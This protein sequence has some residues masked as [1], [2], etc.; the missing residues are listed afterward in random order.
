MVYL[1]L[2]IKTII[3]EATMKTKAILIFT[4]LFTLFVSTVSA[5]S[6]PASMGLGW[7]SQKENTVGNIDFAGN[8]Y[9]G[10]NDSKIYRLLNSKG[11]TLYKYKSPKTI[12]DSVLFKDGTAYLIEGKEWGT[13]DV[14]ALTS[15]GKVK[16]KKSFAG[17]NSMKLELAADGTLYA[18][19]FNSKGWHVFRMN[20]TSGAVLWSS[21]QQGL[22]GIGTNGNVLIPHGDNLEK[23]TMYKNGK[24]AWEG[25]TPSRQNQIEVVTVAPNGN[26][27]IVSSRG[28]LDYYVQ[29]FDSKGKPLF[30]RSIKNNAE[31][32]GQVIFNSNSEL[33]IS[34]L[35]LQGRLKLEWYSAKGKLTNSSSFPLPQPPTTYYEEA[36]SEREFITKVDHKK[37]IYFRPFSITVYKY[38]SA[39]KQVGKTNIPSDHRPRENSN[40][41]LLYSKF[42]KKTGNTYFSL[43]TYR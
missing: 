27:A 3:T 35:T 40:F 1:P 2:Y 32:M 43:Y 9:K 37:N 7:K 33:L 42:D 34:V 14:I 17:Y 22:V 38:N 36:Y 41:G 20:P 26:V 29:V 13:G 28:M 21:A 12:G 19:G 6:V 4:L 39:G 11:T 25:S 10:L 5:A 16:W 31:Q 18:T 8:G 30:V 23:F 24:K 15:A